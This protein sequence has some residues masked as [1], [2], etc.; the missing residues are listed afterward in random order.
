[1]I[2]Y[3]GYG[4]RASK[5]K[6]ISTI[7]I[8]KIIMTQN[9]NA[10]TFYTSEEDELHQR[11]VNVLSNLISQDDLSEAG[12]TVKKEKV[13]QLRLQRKLEKSKKTWKKFFYKLL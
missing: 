7:T 1:M 4:R 3:I 6:K 13:K 2:C 8:Q 5:Y 9:N 11:L 12:E 10:A